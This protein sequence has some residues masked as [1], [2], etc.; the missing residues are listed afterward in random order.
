MGHEFICEMQV[1]LDGEHKLLRLREGPVVDQELVVLERG[2]EREFV[3]FG[4]V[5]QCAHA[6]CEE[7]VEF[8]GG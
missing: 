8:L 6:H 7:F 5:D 3:G 2:R 4:K 1:V